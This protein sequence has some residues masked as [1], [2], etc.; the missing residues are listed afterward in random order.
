[1]S[2]CGS[3]RCVEVVE[4]MYISVLTVTGNSNGKGHVRTMV[5]CTSIFLSYVCSEECIT[6]CDHRH[7]A[8]S[9]V[10]SL[11][12]LN[13]QVLYYLLRFLKVRVEIPAFHSCVHYVLV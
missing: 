6:N 8:V 10:E 4:N 11:P 9:L 5:Q 1:M 7:N 3:G 2:V 12:D 13:K